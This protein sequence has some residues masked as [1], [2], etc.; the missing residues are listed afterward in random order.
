MKTEGL[1][2]LIIVSVLNMFYLYHLAVLTIVR[3]SLIQWDWISD[4]M[5]NIFKVFLWW[6]YI[7]YM[8][9]YRNYNWVLND[10]IFNASMIERILQYVGVVY[11]IS[12]F[13]LYLYSSWCYIEAHTFVYANLYNAYMYTYIYIYVLYIYII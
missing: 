5:L 10:N 8:Y 9:L 3:V 12:H 6:G 7:L 13:F 11:F 1:S 2:F 4:S